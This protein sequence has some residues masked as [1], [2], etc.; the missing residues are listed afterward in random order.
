MKK[1]IYLTTFITLG[2]FLGISF[3][4]TKNRSQLDQYYLDCL[5]SVKSRLIYGSSVDSK[6][7]LEAYEDRTEFYMHLDG[8]NGAEIL[9]MKVQATMESSKEKR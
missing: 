9:N 6:E 2:F 4:N 3:A 1:I 5:K 7:E 8:Y